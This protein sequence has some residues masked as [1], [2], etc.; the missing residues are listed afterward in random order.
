M[1]MCN[2]FASAGHDVTLFARPGPDTG[3][4]YAYYG[5]DRAFEIVKTQ[6]PGTRRL[7]EWRYAWAARNELQRRRPFDLI[8]G[9]HLPS[10]A[11]AT[12]HQTP[13]IYES[14]QPASP[15]GQAIEHLLFRRTN[16]GKVV[17]I[18]EA[19]RQAYLSTYPRLS[20][21]RTQ[22][23]HDGAA[24]SRSDSGSAELPSQNGRLRVGYTGSFSTGRGVEFVARLARR[25][26][27]FDFHVCGGSAETISSCRRLVLNCSN[28]EFHGFV[29]PAMTSSWQKSMDILLAPY[30]CTSPIIR[31]MSPLKVF[32]YMAAR[33]P[34]VA[35]DVPVLY[36]VLEHGKN[37][38]LVSADNAD[39]WE[40]ALR[41][42]S[43]PHRR[44]TLSRN[45]FD[46]FKASYT[47]DFR[48]RNV[49]HGIKQGI[50]A[51]A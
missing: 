1:Q 48:V 41:S 23:C 4:D 34:I 3:D 17:F 20:I 11:L 27:D 50:A 47:W 22:V 46:D 32:E 42:L 37:A 19:L 14:H 35:S 21:H 8:F 45:A 30:Q 38:L 33:R 40:A 10:L 29:A 28:I 9:R 12:V 18:S 15:M 7:R 43:E 31:W 25:L 24:D 36:E 5:V 16:L 6:A 2:A 39:C 49:L 13:F 51:S 26:G 44:D